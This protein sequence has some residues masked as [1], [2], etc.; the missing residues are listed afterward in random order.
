VYCSYDVVVTTT[1]WQLLRP[2]LTR[3]GQ[4]EE[5]TSVDAAA[6]Q[7]VRVPAR[8]GAITLVTIAP[9]RS[10]AEQAS[11]FVL[12]PPE[13]FVTY[14]EQRWRLASSPAA[15]G[16]MLNTPQPHPAFGN[17]PPTPH[18][19]IA[20]TT[21]ARLTFAYIDVIQRVT[22]VDGPSDDRTPILA[23][24]AARSIVAR[25]RSVATSLTEEGCLLLDATGADPQVEL[26]TGTGIT[27]EVSSTTDGLGQVFIGQNGTSIEE[28]SFHLEMAAGSWSRIPLPGGLVRFDP[29]DEGTTLLCQVQ[30]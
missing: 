14:G 9:I 15:P 24:G 8:E 3:C 2:A 22:A 11:D 30:R 23:P 1:A 28:N 16:L 6:G 27:I 12:K 4:L 21:P 18:P 26:R 13:F 7:D 19:T 10:P 29:P 5:A 20:V 25:T 17:L